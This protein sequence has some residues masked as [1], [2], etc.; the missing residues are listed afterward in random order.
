MVLIFL[1]KDDL[2]RYL[3]A[4]PMLVVGLMVSLANW[5]DV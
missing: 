1:T 3:F 4:A 2:D 5:N